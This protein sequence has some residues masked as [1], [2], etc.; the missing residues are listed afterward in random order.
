MEKIFIK[1]KKYICIVVTAI[2][3]FNFLIF[4][5][6][7]S[8]QYVGASANPQ[9]TGQN[10]GLADKIGGAV[11]KTLFGISAD[12]ILLISSA[13]SYALGAVFGMV[14]YLE[15]QIIDYLL[16]P[17]NFPMTNALIVKVGWGI[18]RV[19]S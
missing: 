14:I 16:S 13:I 5:L 3:A 4:P 15:A 18:T 6:T 9:P 11:A 1:N 17:T 7:S 10:T 12:T 2:I 8:A 19:L